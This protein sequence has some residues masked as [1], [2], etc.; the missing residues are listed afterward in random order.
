[1]VGEV[2]AAMVNAVLQAPGRKLLLPVNCS[3]IH[4]VGTEA[5]TLDQLMDLVIKRVRSSHGAVST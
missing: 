4:V 5:G 3:G 1:M 2:T